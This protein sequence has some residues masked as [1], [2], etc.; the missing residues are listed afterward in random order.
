MVVLYVTVVVSKC[1]QGFSWCS[2][3]RRRTSCRVPSGPAGAG[4]SCTPWSTT[5]PWWEPGSTSSGRVR[6]ASWM[7]A[8]SVAPRREAKRRRPRWQRPPHTTEKWV[9]D[10]VSLDL[11][12]VLSFYR[13]S[14]QV[15]VW[16][17]IELSAACAVFHFI[18]R[19]WDTEGHVPK[20]QMKSLF[21]KP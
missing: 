20:F 1:P 15:F 11:D 4:S 12:C 14:K 16:Q 8:S 7:G 9:D 17:Q 3:R 18:W 21:L 2:R 13:L 10:G 5:P 6:R 19:L